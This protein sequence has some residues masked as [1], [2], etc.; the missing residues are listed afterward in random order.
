MDTLHAKYDTLKAYLQELGSA[1]VAFSSGV[2]STFLLKTAHDVLGDKA[3]A[4]T[5]VSG[6]F[7]ARESK[8]AEEFCRQNGI[9]QIICRLDEMNIPGFR[10]NPPDRCYLCKR[11]I[12][13]SILKLAEEN[14]AAAVCEGSNMDDMGD[15]RP[16]MTRSGS[17]G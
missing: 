11:E 5:A 14:G 1:A 9:R 16:G 12:F 8:E 4:I 10:E 7:P 15:Y 2:D 6:S 13:N 17:W 3:I